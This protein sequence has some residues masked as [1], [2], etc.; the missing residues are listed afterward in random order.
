MS[1]PSPYSEGFDE[2]TI[3]SVRDA[4]TA[5]LITATP[6]TNLMEAVMVMNNHRIGSL[7]V[8][9]AGK[10]VGIVTERDIMTKVV[11]RA[12]SALDLR[13]ADVMS[14]QVTSI[15]E[16]GTL[17]DAA[18]LMTRYGIRRLPVVNKQGDLVGIISSMDI[19]REFPDLMSILSRPVR[20]AQL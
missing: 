17:K 13:V 15:I 14:T 11:G 9:R 10:P 4:M 5:Q 16:D 8:I 1:S 7:V 6:E 3:L 18:R 19:I 20:L 12:V 2:P